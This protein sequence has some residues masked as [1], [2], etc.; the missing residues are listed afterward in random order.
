MAREIAS[1]ARDADEKRWVAEGKAAR[2][3]GL[4]QLQLLVVGSDGVIRPVFQEVAPPFCMLT[5]V[6]AVDSPSPLS[7]LI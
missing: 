3:K 1:A 6:V 4:E 2:E 7:N 5:R